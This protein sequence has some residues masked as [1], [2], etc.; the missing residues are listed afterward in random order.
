MT[1]SSKKLF[2]R[3]LMTIGECSRAIKE[4]LIPRKNYKSRL[5]SG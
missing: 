1:R 2:G 3:I 4:I 5:F